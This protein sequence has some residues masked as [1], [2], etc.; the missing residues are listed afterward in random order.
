MDSTLLTR[1]R[2]AFARSSISPVRS[3]KSMAILTASSS[4]SG[5]ASSLNQ[6]DMTMSLHS[7]PLPSPNAKGRWDSTV[8]S[9]IRKPREAA[10]HE[11]ERCA[12]VSVGQDRCSNG[13]SDEVEIHQ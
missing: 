4:R 9:K 13:N 3:R 10:P 7:V 12:P 8:G 2:E 5:G 6:T 1:K 11:L